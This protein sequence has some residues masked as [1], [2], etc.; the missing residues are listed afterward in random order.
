MFEGV[1]QPMHLLVIFLV[2]IFL[3]PARHCRQPVLA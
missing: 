2:G 1:F 3:L